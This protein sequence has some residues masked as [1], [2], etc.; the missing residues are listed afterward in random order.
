[1]LSLVHTN[2][3][4]I[5]LITISIFGSCSCTLQRNITNLAI[6]II[7]LT[8]CIKIPFGVSINL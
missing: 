6:N 5:T 3:S 7:R 1:M 2:K 4:L 8:T